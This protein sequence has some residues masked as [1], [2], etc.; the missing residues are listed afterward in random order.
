MAKTAAPSL[1]EAPSLDSA[2]ALSPTDARKV[3]DILTP[4]S[5]KRQAFIR[6]VV[7]GNTL[8]LAYRAA[9]Y[10]GVARIGGTRLSVGH[11]S[12]SCV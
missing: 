11:A 8:A 7:A 9:G 1:P 2:S 12:V 4:L 10:S 3:A 6:A 5:L